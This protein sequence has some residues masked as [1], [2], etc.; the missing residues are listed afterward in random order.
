MRGFTMVEIMVVVSII[1]ILSAIIYAGF[2]NAREQARTRALQTEIKEV[3]LAIEVFKA[4]HGRYP[5]VDVAN[6]ANC[7]AGLMAQQGG[8]RGGSNCANFVNYIGEGGIGYLA[9]DFIASLPLARDSNN[10]NCVI[11]YETNATGDWYKLTAHR[12]LEGATTVAEGIGEDE[13]FSL[14]PSS[15]QSIGPGTCNG[16]AYDETAPGFYESMAVYSF[17]GECQ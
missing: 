4:Q 12:C 14:C 8:M 2:D 7:A 1:A 9:P 3:Q 16:V 15:C 11:T 10:P 5:G 6:Q 17:G 13:Q